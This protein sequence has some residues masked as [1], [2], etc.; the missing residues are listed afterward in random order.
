MTTVG[1]AISGYC[2]IG[3]TCDA[4]KPAIVMMIE[5]TPAKIGR[6]MKNS[7]NDIVRERYLGAACG[8]PGAVAAAPA[9]DADIVE[10][11]VAAGRGAP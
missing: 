6:L 10:A 7:E 9:V 4:I 3:S 1:G 5:M 2:A 11:L 8:A